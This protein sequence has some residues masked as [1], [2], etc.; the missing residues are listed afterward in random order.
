MYTTSEMMFL[1]GLA[2]IIVIGFSTVAVICIA[3][4]LRKD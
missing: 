4:S 1:I 3:D 2:A